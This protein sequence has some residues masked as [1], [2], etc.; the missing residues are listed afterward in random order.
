MFLVQVHTNNLGASAA[1]HVDLTLPTNFAIT[2]T[3]VDY[4]T[5]CTGAGQKLD[6]DLGTIT[7]DMHPIYIRVTGKVTKPGEMDAT[8]TVS[9]LTQPEA[10]ATLADNTST[11]TI[12][13]AASPG[14]GQIVLGSKN[15]GDPRYEV[16]WGTAHPRVIYNGGDPSGKVWNIQW[17]EWGGTATRGRGHTWI[18]RPHGGYFKN[19]ALIELRAFGI[20]RCS[21]KGPSAYRHLEVRVQT[22]PGGPLGH[23]YTW[24]GSS[25]VCVRS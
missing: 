10:D 3:Q 15:F 24:G 8:A 6:C 22:Y 11:L 14:L 17:S 23:W 5:G 19:S 7:Y 1:V 2:Q 16:G 9:S 4:G 25:S 21:P 20:G 18:S 13:A 12:P